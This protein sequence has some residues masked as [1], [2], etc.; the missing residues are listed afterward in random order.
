MDMYSLTV[1]LERMLDL[2]V[3]QTTSGNPSTYAEIDHS[4]SEYQRIFDPDRS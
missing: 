3:G 4:V 2:S 1:V